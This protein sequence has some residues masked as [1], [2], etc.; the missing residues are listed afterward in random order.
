MEKI[1]RKKIKRKRKARSIKSRNEAKSITNQ[2]TLV[3]LLKELKK[4][5]GSLAQDRVHPAALLLQVQVAHLS[6]K[7]Q[8]IRNLKTQNYIKITLRTNSGAS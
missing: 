1:G 8:E 2:L 4:K 7:D 3:H 5:E 6:V